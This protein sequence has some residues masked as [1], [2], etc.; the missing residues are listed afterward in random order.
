VPCAHNDDGSVVDLPL[1]Y[2]WASLNVDEDPAVDHHDIDT[3]EEEEEGDH[4]NIPDEDKEEEDDENHPQKQALPPE[5]SAALPWTHFV[6]MKL[7]ARR[8][9]RQLPPQQRVVLHWE[10]ALA[11]EV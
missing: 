9:R 5:I 7:L 1:S 2:P 8:L 10:Y 11:Q 4:R 6:W 3:H